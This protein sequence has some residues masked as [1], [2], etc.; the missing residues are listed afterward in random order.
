MDMPFL[1]FLTLE[2]GA[3]THLSGIFEELVERPRVVFEFYNSLIFYH[4][5]YVL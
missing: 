4:R 1:A 3:E 5:V 2:H